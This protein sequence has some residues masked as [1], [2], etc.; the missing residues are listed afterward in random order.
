MIIITFREGKTMSIKKIL[1]DCRE[2]NHPNF[3]AGT[4]HGAVA[5]AVEDMDV[6]DRVVVEGVINADGFRLDDYVA[7]IRSGLS[8]IK[9]VGHGSYSSRFSAEHGL[10][11]T[12]E[13][14]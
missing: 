6:F 1:I 14:D 8:R 9:D 2:L 4:L 10:L 5:V 12:K 13:G 7:R 11:V 3:R